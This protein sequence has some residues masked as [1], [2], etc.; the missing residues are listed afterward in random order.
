MQLMINKYMLYISQIQYYQIAM[1]SKVYVN[2][3]FSESSKTQQR[4]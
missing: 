3:F 2:K 4:G 1:Q